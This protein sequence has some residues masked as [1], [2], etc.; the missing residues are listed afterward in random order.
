MADL[1]RVAWAAPRMAAPWWLNVR[2]STLVGG[3]TGAGKGSV[4]WGLLVGLAP[5]I[6]AGTVRVHGVDLKGGME[7]A[8]GGPLFTSWAT[9]PADA[10]AL[11]EDVVVECQARARSL[12]GRARTHTLVGASRWC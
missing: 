2:V 8:L 12:A 10:V 4:M 1:D 11:L 3:S 5:A 9:T 7:L 6:H